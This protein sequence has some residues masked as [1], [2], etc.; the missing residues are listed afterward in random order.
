MTKNKLIQN[1]GSSETIRN[2]SCM[3]YQWI[4]GLIDADGGFYIS[5]SNNIF[6]KQKTTKKSYVSCEITMHEKEIQTLYYI[7]SRLSGSINRRKGKKAY[8][9][10]LH[11]KQPIETLCHN[12]NGLFKTVRIEKQF[13][14]VCNL[15]G[16]Q[17]L[18]RS[19]FNLET[20]WFSG[21]FSGDGSF[22]INTKAKF[23]PSISIAQKEKSILDEIATLVGG[24]VYFDKSWN[25]WIW[26]IDARVV[27][28][29]FWSYFNNYPLNNPLK[30]ARLKSI[31]RF[32]GYL[33]R[34]L[35]K[36]PNSQGRLLHFVR[37]FL[38]FI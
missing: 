1:V 27:H 18:P 13:Q 29:S 16:I 21:F 3:F 19:P 5:N 26:W 12:L 4:A 34:N 38:L 8:R 15:Y 33:K 2:E 24:K 25:G 31:Q 17:Q 9:W 28:Q 10:R 23:Q 14:K 35:H 20:A 37:L 22:F 7:K 11:K 30:K 6:C 32:L 36:D